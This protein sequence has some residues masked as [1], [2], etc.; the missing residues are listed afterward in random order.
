MCELIFLCT[1]PFFLWSPIYNSNNTGFDAHCKT[2]GRIS[3]M[4]CW[5][6]WAFTNC[7]SFLKENHP[8]IPKLIDISVWG[9]MYPEILFHKK[10]NFNECKE[11]FGC[12]SPQ[13]LKKAYNSEK[14]DYKSCKGVLSFLIVYLVPVPVFPFC[15][16]LY[17]CWFSP[18]CSFM[19]K[20]KNV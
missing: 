14:K 19:C 4:K 8:E 11:S 7:L 16:Y 5:K 9:G 20:T 1:L 13:L 6:S 17:V 15:R 12:E 2:T 10:L 18:N 3:R